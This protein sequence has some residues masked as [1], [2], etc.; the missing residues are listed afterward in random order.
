MDSVTCAVYLLE[1]DLQAYDALIWDEPKSTRE[2]RSFSGK[3]K[4]SS[5]RLQRVRR[6][7]PSRE[8]PDVWKILGSA[9]FAASQETVEAL[10]PFLNDAGEL[11]LFIIADKNEVILAM[12]VFELSIAWI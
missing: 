3:P 12:N 4:L 5:W 2:L 6:D 11:L 9:A 10:Q 7:N 1:A 8:E